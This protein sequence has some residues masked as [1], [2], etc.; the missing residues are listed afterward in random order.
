MAD[1]RKKDVAWKIPNNDDGTVSWNGTQLAVLM[2]IRDE[3]KLLNG[4]L[5]CA[6]FTGIPWTL[7]AIEANTKKARPMRK[8]R[9]A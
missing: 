9:A 8:R 3:L 2:D 6:N 7:K 5:Q 1:T 4:F